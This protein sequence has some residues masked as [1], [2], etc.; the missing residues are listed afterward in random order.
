MFNM[1]ETSSR[2]EKAIVGNLFNDLQTDPALVDP[3]TFKFDE[4]KELLKIVVE[5]RE[6]G[7]PI[8]YIFLKH[9]ES[10]RRLDLFEECTALGASRP[11]F[12]TNLRIHR[13]TA[14][15]I[16]LQEACGKI[17]QM[18][19]TDIEKS[20]GKLKATID[21]IESDTIDELKTIDPANIK[22]ITEDT[23]QRFYIPTGFDAIDD[24]LN[25]LG[26]GQVTLIAGRS[27]EGKSTFTRQIIANA[28]EK[29]RS[30]LWV[31]GESTLEAELQNLYEIVIGRNEQYYQLVKVNKVYMK[32]PN[33]ETRAA[34]NR[35]HKGMLW[36]LSKSEARLK[37]TD[38]LLNT[39]K[40]E[41]RI[42]KPQL[43][44]VDNL[45]SVLNA[46]A[47]EKNEAQSTF[48][49]TLCDVARLSG[50]HVI[51]VLH[52]NKL[53]RKGERMSYE[54]ISGSSDLV[55][56]CD[57]L[58]VVR[59]ASEEDAEK[60]I[61]GHV[62]I[63]KNRHRGKLLS[64]KTKYDIHTKGLAE[65][66]GNKAKIKTFDISRYFDLNLKFWNGTTQTV[67]QGKGYRPE[68]KQQKE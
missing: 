56:K 68:P 48:M 12:E 61:D 55:N 26:P 66:A 63:E 16:K 51:L 9:E 64:I 40:R 47:L 15:A 39:I 13:K 34:L 41:M 27:H 14:A 44:V 33:P 45:M 1:I 37:S 10:G 60:G 58:L 23:D 22:L 57:N 43:I 19:V 4:L 3:N 28:I 30:V 42:R 50:C 54:H 65:I 17:S 29:R 67:E 38:E 52:P 24:A 59:K 35:W 8:G 18:S 2:I 20:L 21:K 6:Q 49:Q 46:T 7:D 11:S 31:V 36:M 62:D 5:S 25:D 53:Y 32:Q